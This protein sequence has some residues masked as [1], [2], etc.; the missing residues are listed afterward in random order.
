[1]PV[2]FCV[3]A[4]GA[5]SL[6]V[7][8]GYADGH[9]RDAAIIKAA[10]EH[11]AVAVGFVSTVWFSKSPVGSPMLTRPSRDPDRVEAVLITAIRKGDSAL[12]SVA[13]I[14]RS[15]GR[16]P[17]LRPWRRTTGGEGALVDALR[18]AVT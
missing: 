8:D 4:N 15:P 11:K 12:S 17:T 1:M 9:H 2:L 7:L 13:K 10:R 16:P 6:V 14:V 3:D 18:K 5:I